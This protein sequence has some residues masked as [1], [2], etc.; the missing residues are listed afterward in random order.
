M[1][2]QTNNIIMPINTGER[3]IG[4]HTAGSIHEYNHYMRKN[5]QG[6]TDS[7]QIHDI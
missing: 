5:Y 7:Y 2:E 6:M 1:L 4:Q 3:P